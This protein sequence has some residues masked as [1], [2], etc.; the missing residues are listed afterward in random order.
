LAADFM[1]CNTEKLKVT[2]EELRHKY[3]FGLIYMTAFF[4]QYMAFVNEIQNAKN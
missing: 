4:K 1:S 3:G 2:G